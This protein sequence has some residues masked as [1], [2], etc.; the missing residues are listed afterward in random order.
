MISLRSLQIFI[1]NQNLLSRQVFE[2][3]KMNFPKQQLGGRA[4]REKNVRLSG[5]VSQTWDAWQLHRTAVPALFWARQKS[6]FREHLATQ[7]SS[8]V[9][10]KLGLDGWF[11]AWHDGSKLLSSLSIYFF[12]SAYAADRHRQAV[13]TLNVYNSGLDRLGVTHF[14]SFRDP[15]F[16]NHCHRGFTKI[17]QA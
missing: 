11:L 4:V 17:W 1:W 2:I 10:K 16:G 3:L 8:N 5:R 14:L 9:W 6:E 12:S 7:A 15:Y 13:V